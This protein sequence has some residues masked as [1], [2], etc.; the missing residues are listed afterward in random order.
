MIDSR[1]LRPLALGPDWIARLLPHRPPLLLVD[2]ITHVGDAPPSLAALKNVSSAEPVF[3]GHFPGKPIWPGA[4]TIEGL[5]Q[6]CALVA[7][8]QAGGISMTA[9]PAPGVGDFP[10][11]QGTGLLAGVDLKL[12][13][14]VWPGDRLDYRV[15]RT[16][17]VD[18]FHR[19]DAEA[20]VGN[21]RVASGTLMLAWR[22][23]P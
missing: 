20:A 4:Y 7:A 17:E 15:A 13:H 12:I 22:P 1:S 3:A 2:A 23:A 11:P 19:F 21:R 18:G 6:C 16:H 8:V 5:A 10:M 9:A 14:P